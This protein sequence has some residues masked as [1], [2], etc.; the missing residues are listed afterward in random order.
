[1]EIHNYNKGYLIFFPF[2]LLKKFYYNISFCFSVNRFAVGAVK[3][4]IKGFTEKQ[5]MDI[6]FDN[7]S[8]V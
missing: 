3:A 5:K 4:I 1:M 6:L 7:P 8:L 2:D